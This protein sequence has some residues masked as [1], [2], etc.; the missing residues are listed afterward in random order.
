MFADYRGDANVVEDA[1]SRGLVSWKGLV[2]NIDYLDLDDPI[3]RIVGRWWRKWVKAEVQ[4][5]RG[6]AQADEDEDEE[7]DGLRRA[8]GRGKGGMPTGTL[9]EDECSERGDEADMDGEGEGD[10][11]EGDRAIDEAMIGALK[12]L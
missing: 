9:S 8:R 7:D 4:G 5:S 3:K 2:H 11:E 10:V 12:N 1:L 6:V